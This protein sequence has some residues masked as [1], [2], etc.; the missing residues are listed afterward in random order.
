MTNLNILE[1]FRTKE[2]IMNYFKEKGIKVTDKQLNSLKEKYED[3]KTKD[4]A[5]DLQQ[6]D[7]V[8]GGIYYLE[9]GDQEFLHKDKPK[10]LDTTTAILLIPHVVVSFIEETIYIDFRREEVNQETDKKNLEENVNFLPISYGDRVEY[11]PIN[12]EL[13][14]EMAGVQKVEEI[15]QPL[16]NSII[17][18]MDVKEILAKCPID[19]NYTEYDIAQRE[20]LLKLITFA[21]HSVSAIPAPAA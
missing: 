18:D 1:G 14:I 13:I 8:V 21:T 17:K 19:T 20:N 11:M 4:N 9:V 7:K 5:L 2:E 6:L 10:F 3:T 12:P 15:K 16:I